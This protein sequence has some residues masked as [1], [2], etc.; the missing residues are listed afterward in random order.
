MGLSPG[1][2][3]VLDSRNPEQLL[4]ALYVQTHQLPET[5]ALS[6]KLL[7]PELNHVAEYDSVVQLVL[8]DVDD[9][10]RL[11]DDPEFVQKIQPD[12]QHFADTSRT[13]YIYL[14][15]DSNE[16][17]PNHSRMSVGYVTPLVRDNKAVPAGER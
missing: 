11:K 4:T 14:S 17:D 8:R 5:L 16:R 6:S 12:H 10:V 3:Q 9:F 2:W 1:Q 15:S 13:K 7:N